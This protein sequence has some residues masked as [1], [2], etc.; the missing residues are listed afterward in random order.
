MVSGK[1]LQMGN[2][3]VP[4]K[5]S[6]IDSTGLW[7]T[8]ELRHFDR[9]SRENDHGQYDRLEYVFGPSGA[10]PLYSRAMLEDIAFQGEYSDEDFVIYREDADLAWRARFRAG[11]ASTL[12]WP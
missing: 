9:G 8:P 12:P 7:F 2:D 10:A 5:P 3:M 11:N 6:V 4:I 1:L